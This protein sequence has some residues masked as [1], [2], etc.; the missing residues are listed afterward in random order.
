MLWKRNIFEKVRP[1]HV[2][3]AVREPM[4]RNISVF[5]QNFEAYNHG[6]NFTGISVEQAT[7]NFVSELP[8]LLVDK[9]FK[10]DFLSN[11]NLDYE[12][13]AF[14]DGSKYSLVEKKRSPDSRFRTDLVLLRRNGPNR[15]ERH[16][17]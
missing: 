16:L 2:I 7:A 9:W 6:I 5:F 3:S 10:E 11:L 4:A 13:I 12:D 1:C 8:H 14:K 17:L 15:A